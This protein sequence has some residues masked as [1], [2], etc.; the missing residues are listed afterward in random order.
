MTPA[1]GYYPR[2]V[3]RATMS[4]SPT[5]AWYTNIVKRKYAKDE[6]LYYISTISSHIFLW[7]F[8]VSFLRFKRYLISAA[9]GAVIHI[10]LSTCVF[11]N[12]AYLFVVC[13]L[14]YGLKVLGFV[15]DYTFL[16]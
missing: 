11:S 7:V 3:L 12:Y 1:N 10:W 4:G 2:D 5:A 14:W 6:Y 16:N 15:G 9:S 8:K 13:I